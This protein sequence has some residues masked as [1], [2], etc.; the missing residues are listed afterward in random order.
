MGAK[1]WAKESFEI[2]TKFAYQNGAL[3]GI[4]KGQRKDC[5]EVADA[6]VLPEDYPATARAIEDR[7]MILAGID[8]W[9]C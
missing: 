8:W 9:G 6:A 7:R 5:R 2:A 1:A 3:R 4:P